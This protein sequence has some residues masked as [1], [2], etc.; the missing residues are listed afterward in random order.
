MHPTK[1]TQQQL[2]H[3]QGP[4]A[5]FLGYFRLAGHKGLVSWG[6]ARKFP[7]S[8]LETIIFYYFENCQK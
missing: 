8:V 4:L 5:D 1:E 6:Q 3:L 2:C 7:Y